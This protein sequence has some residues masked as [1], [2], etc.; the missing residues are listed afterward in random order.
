[1][2][3]SLDLAV[4]YADKYPTDPRGAVLF[5]FVTLSEH[6]NVDQVKRAYSSLSTRYGESQQGKFGAYMLSLMN[7]LGRSFDFSFED[8]V[9]G[10]KVTDESLRGKIVVVDFWATWC[11]P[12]IETLPRMKE[13]Y[14]K[15]K[16]KGVEF[17]GISLDR[18]EQEGGRKALLDF[19]KENKMPWPQ[20]Y[21]KGRTE[22]LAEYGVSQIPT[23]FV[24]D[25]QGKI[26]SIDGYR[27]LDRT[28]KSLTE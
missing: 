18:A 7:N 4:K 6:A 14:A 19:V 27:V 10:R 8:E 26:H 21:L 11:G 23:I 20:Y 13:T 2:E 16:S 28:L 22:F 1:M 24:L 15:Y 17:V 5:N 3:T 12:C 9:T 25:R